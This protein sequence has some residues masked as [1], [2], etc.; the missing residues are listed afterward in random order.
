MLKEY[1]RSNTV[2]PQHEIYKPLFTVFNKEKQIADR[3]FEIPTEKNHKKPFPIRKLW[4]DAVTLL[5]IN[6]S[7]YK[8]KAEVQ[9]DNYLFSKTAM[10]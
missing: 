1:F 10:K 8:N 3:M 6:L 2:L 5:I 7:P 4:F 9:S